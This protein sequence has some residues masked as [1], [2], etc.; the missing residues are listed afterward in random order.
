MKINWI[1]LISFILVFSKKKKLFE[2][3]DTVIILNDNN[4]NKTINKIENILVL[5]YA[6]WCGHC[7]KF[8]PT[9]TKISKKLYDEKPR[10]NLAKIEMSKNNLMKEQYKINSFPTIKFFHKGKAYDYIEEREEEK[11]IK[12]MKKKIYSSVRNITSIYD[13]SN[14][15]DNHKISLIYFGDSNE[16][17]S[18]LDKLI[19][20]DD[21]IFYAFCSDKKIFN[22]YGFKNGSLILYKDKGKEKYE[23]NG[24]LTEDN[25][26][27]FIENYSFDKLLIFNKR[28]SKFLFEKKEPSLILF[29][30]ENNDESIKYENLFYELA[31][32]LYK[33][34]RIYISDVYSFKI[35]N[36]KSLSNVKDNETPTIRLYDPRKNN[37]TFYRFNNTINEKNILKFIDDFEKGK[38]KFIL[39]SDNVII[40]KNKYDIFELVGN[41]FEDEVLKSNFNYFVLFYLPYYEISETLLKQYE[42]L[43]KKY[44]KEKEKYNLKIGKINMYSNEVPPDEIPDYYPFLRLYLKNKN[45]EIKEYKGNYT[46]V[47]AI[48]K[49]LNDNFDNLNK[50][51]DL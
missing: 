23:L 18:Y 48:I 20:E 6:S 30:K 51:E 41:N 39:K 44:K 17:I 32:K 11:I 36:K 8:E 9:F 46:N 35:Q 15:R 2:R 10:I 24:K 7:K 31:Q 21:E 19:E 16:I 37:K 25:I 45:N 14:L 29:R 33:R 34:I 3:E 13:I 50:N 38:L 27:K 49:F 28:T 43:N 26:V 5:F 1:I 22:Y 40:P 47:N 12:W 42:E 4:F